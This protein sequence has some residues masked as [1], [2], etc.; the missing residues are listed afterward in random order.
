MVKERNEQPKRIVD[1]LEETLDSLYDPVALQ[2]NPLIEILNLETAPHPASALRHALIDAIEALRPNDNTPLQT[3]A[4]R[5]YNLLSQRYVEQLSQKTV[6]RNLALSPRQLRRIRPGALQELTGYLC[7]N[8][9]VRFDVQL[10]AEGTPEHDSEE[11]ESLQSQEIRRISR[12]YPQTRLEMTPLLREVLTTVR[13]LLEEAG[14]M[15]ECDLSEQVPPLAAQSS[16]T[17]HLFLSLLSTLASG[18]STGVLQI[19][20][21]LDTPCG[22]VQI[23]PGGISRPAALAMSEQ[24]DQNKGLLRHLA[25]ATSGSLETKFDDAGCLET[26][27]VRLPLVD[28]ATVLIV[29]DNVDSLKL[30]DRFLSGTR[31]RA[32][33]LSDESETVSVAEANHPDIIVLDLLLPDTDGWQLLERLRENPRTCDIPVLICTILPQK[34]LA[35]TLGAAGFVRKPITRG[36]FLAA[37]DEHC[38]VMVQQ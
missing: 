6:A 10:L 17:K 20:V 14:V 16:T 35:L 31:Y 7:E 15:I 3:N 13:P 2:N 36:R 33:C 34:Q 4:W 11:T 25:A 21:T 12:N 30:L 9:K 23:K 5:F 19:E 29:D 27:T 8:H 28:Q 22:L 32:I 1:I 18:M 26:I 24:F 37:L 38:V